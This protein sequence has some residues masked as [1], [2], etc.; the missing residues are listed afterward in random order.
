MTTIRTIR[1]PHPEAPPA[2][3][4]DRRRRTA[5]ARGRT[6]PDRRG[7]LAIAAWDSEGGF[8]PR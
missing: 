4:P 8:Q 5:P 1:R 3:P 7:T 2:V 6:A